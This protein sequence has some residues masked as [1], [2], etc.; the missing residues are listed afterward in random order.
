M[1]SDGYRAGPG[2]DRPPGRARSGPGPPMG[3]GRGLTAQCR[4]VELAGDSYGDAAAEALEAR[5]HDVPRPGA[6]LRRGQDLARP[7]PGAAT[8]QE[9][10][11][12]EGHS[13]T[14][15]LGLRLDGVARMGRRTRARSWRESAPGGR[16]PLACSPPPSFGSPAS[17]STG[18]PTRRSRGPSSSPS[19]PSSSTS[20]TPTPSSASDPACSWPRGCSTRASTHGPEGS[21]PGAEPP[22]SSGVP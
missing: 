21:G 19:T 22:I 7:R 13:R 20:A 17:P 10:G 14:R 5:G 18:C 2:G 4:M 15:R 11:R 3:A 16:R 9:V 1:E 8:S 6:G 12:S